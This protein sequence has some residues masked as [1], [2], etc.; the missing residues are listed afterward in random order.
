MSDFVH[1]HCHTEYS[2]FDS[3]IR[4]RDL[5]SKAREYGMR[6]A[7]ITDHGGLFGV[8]DFYLESQKA[9]I[10]PILGCEV[11]VASTSHED[12]APLTDEPFHLVLLAQNIE[13]YRNLLKLV[14][15]AHLQGCRHKPRV[16]KKLLAQHNQGLIALSACLAG[17]IPRALATKGMGAGVAAAKEYAAI[18]PERFYIELQSNGLKEQDSANAQLIELANH[19]KLPLVATNDCHY[20]TA[21]DVEA[22]DILLCIQTA[23]CV[24]DEKRMRF[25]TKELYYKSPE[26]MEAAFRHVPEAISNTA[27]IAEQC[28][29]KLNLTDYH[30]PTYALPEGKTLQE[31]FAD[32][33]RKGL[34][35][36][37]AK[38]PASIDRP[39]YKERL[40][41]ELQVIDSMGF[42]GYFL[43]VQDF[44]NWAKAQSIPVGPGSGN[45]AGSLV[46][47]ALCITDIDPIQHKLFFER[48]LNNERIS[49]PDIYIDVCE[50][51]RGE[52][53]DYL[54]QT[55]GRDFVAQ[56]AAFKKMKTKETVRNVAQALRLSSD[57][58]ERISK[59]IPPCDPMISIDNALDQTPELQLLYQSDPAAKRLLDISR[60]LHG[61]RCPLSRHPSL[62]VLCDTPLHE[63][64]PLCKNEKNER[65]TQFNAEMVDEIGL[66]SFVIHGLSALTRL[67][68][69]LDIIRSQGQEPPA[70]GSLSLNDPATYDLFS[71]GDTADV[72]LF[73]G[74]GI[75]R[76]LRQLKP[77]CFED[78]VALLTLY[79]PGPLRMGM[80]DDLIKRKQEVR[81]INYPLPQLED[82]L[83]ETYGVITYQEQMMEIAKVIANFTLGRAD[84]MRRALFKINACEMTTHRI[85]FVEGASQNGIPA[86][87]AKELF[88]LLVKFTPYTGCKAHYASCALL[89]F[90][91]GYLKTH[92]LL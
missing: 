13:G 90:Q 29:V 4:V 11:Y 21:G 47:W 91:T 33:S 88:D 1:L 64:L 61:I 34:D 22:H 76:R 55:Y 25:D 92:Y 37:L 56:V 12:R 51:R 35:A 71:R 5:C 66:L 24:D 19:L 87:K 3:T 15:I 62:V 89:S 46:A 78:L 69:T 45:A 49:M 32:L 42:A 6:A 52:V 59:L 63:H 82:V 67:Q 54:S 57:E 10:K 84:M 80:V 36:R 77:T 7:A 44:I 38:R 40:E 23:A 27:S 68:Q 73:E 70:L 53:I 81:L 9:G 17:E 50:R 14:S 41:H 79:L 65:I 58:G 31:E 48:F 60:R 16:D 8:L 26:E 86:T 39:L 28:N 2:F 74:V 83:K 72:F 43:I 85:N 20:L 30:F 18:F 75:R